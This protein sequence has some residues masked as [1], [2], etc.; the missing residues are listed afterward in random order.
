MDVTEIEQWVLTYKQL[1]K[2]NSPENLNGSVLAT[3]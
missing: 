2:S 3:L 1:V